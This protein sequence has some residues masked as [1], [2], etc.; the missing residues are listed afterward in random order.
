MIGAGTSLEGGGVGVGE[1]A[2]VSAGLVTSTL[3][4][5][6]ESTGPKPGSKTRCVPSQLALDSANA[7]P[8]KPSACPY[9]ETSLRPFVSTDT[10][11]LPPTLETLE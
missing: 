7:R 5:G 11:T 4:S 8:P 9:L 3:G 6:P 10:A 2:G 1:T